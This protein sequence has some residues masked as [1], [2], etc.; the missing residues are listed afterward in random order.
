MVMASRSEK[1]ASCDLV[2]VLIPRP[3]KPPDPTIKV[4]SV[5]VRMEGDAEKEVLRVMTKKE[6]G[7]ERGS[8]SGVRDVDRKGDNPITWAGLF[9]R[10]RQE[11]VWGNSKELQEKISKIQ[12]GAKGKVLIEDEDLE[13]AREECK[14]LLYVGWR[15][16]CLRLKR[17]HLTVVVEKAEDK[18]VSLSNEL[19]GKLFAAFAKILNNEHA[20]EDFLEEGF[21]PENSRGAEKRE[22]NEY[23]WA[24]V[25]IQKVNLIFLFE[26]HLNDAESNSFLGRRRRFWERDFVSSSGRAGGLMMMW[27]KGRMQ[28]NIVYKDEQS[29]NAIVELRKGRFCLVSGIMLVLM[30]RGFKLWLRLRR[31]EEGEINQLV[32]DFWNKNRKNNASLEE[33]LNCL[34]EELKK[35]NKE[36]IGCLESKWKEAMKELEKLETKEAVVGLS[37]AEMQY[38]RMLNRKKDRERLKLQKLEELKWN[39]L[40]DEDKKILSNK[41][42]IEELWNAVFGLGRGKCPRLD[43]YIA[44]FYILNWTSMKDML[45]E[46]VDKVFNINGVCSRRFRSFRGIRQGDP[47]SPYLFIIMEEALS[48][49][50]RSYIEKGKITP[51]QMKDTIISHQ[52][53]ADDILFDIKVRHRRGNDNWVWNESKDGVMT[54]RSAY[55]YLKNKE[56]LEEGPGVV[57]KD[58]WNMKIAQNA[59]VFIWK[60][61]WGRLPV[62]A[63]FSKFNNALTEK[64]WVCKQD[65]D[66]M[67]HIF[68]KCSFANEYWTYAERQLG[69]SFRF[70]NEWGKGEWLKEGE[71]FDRDSATGLKAFLANSFWR[72]WKNRNRMKHDGKSWGV[73]VLFTYVLDET[74]Q[75][76]FENKPLEVGMIK[77]SSNEVEAAVQRFTYQC[78]ASWYQGNRAGFGYLFGSENRWMYASFGTGVADNSLM[79]ETMVM[80]FGLDNVRKKGW[81]GLEACSDCEVLIKMLND[82]LVV[83][84]KLT[85]VIGKLRR[86]K[87]EGVVSCWKYI[88]REINKEAH[89]LAKMGLFCNSNFAWFSYGNQVCLDDE[90]FGLKLESM[91]CILIRIWIGFDAKMIATRMALIVRTGLQFQSRLDWLSGGWLTSSDSPFS[92]YVVTASWFIWHARNT[93]LHEGGLGVVIRDCSGSCLG[94]ASLVYQ[95]DSILVLEA[96]AILEGLKMAIN[97]NLSDFIIESDSATVV[98]SLTNELDPPWVICGINKVRLREMGDMASLRV[99][100][101]VAVLLCFEEAVES[102]FSRDDFPPDFIFG[103]G[104][105]AY[106]VEGAAAEDGRTPSVWDTFTHAGSMPRIELEIRKSRVPRM[107]VQQEPSGTNEAEEKSPS[108]G[109]ECTNSEKMFLGFHMKLIKFA[110]GERGKHMFVIPSLDDTIF[111]LREGN[112]LDDFT[113]FANVCFKEF[114]DR[115]SRW[116]T[117]AQPN[118]I[119]IA[120]YDTGEWPPNRCS[121]PFGLGICASGNS[122]IEPYIAVH[123]I[124][125]AHASVV[126]LYR[127]KYQ[128]VQKGEIG[129]N[130]Y[131]YWCYPFTDSAADIEA[132]QRA[133]DFSIGWIANP[134]VFGDYPEVMKKIVGSRLPSFSK[135]QSKQL[136]GSFDYFG[137]NYYTSAYVM[138]DFN[139]AKTGPH[140]YGADMSVLMK[141]SRNDTPGGQFDPTAPSLIDPRGLQ[142]LL[143]YFRDAY[144]NP[145]IFVEENGYGISRHSDEF[146]DIERVDFLSDHISSTLDA[147]RNGANV[148]GYFVW[149]FM[150]VFEFLAGYQ[151]RCGLYFVN[152]DDERR[153]RRPKLSANWF[154]NFL[155][156]KTKIT[157]NLDDKFHSQV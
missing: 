39:T 20:K 87:N 86:L 45:M 141:S 34:K 97:R 47:L 48:V 93:K 103:A 10:S 155:I 133:L 29:I 70:K 122:T 149:S 83:P 154:T 125:L 46:E 142:H 143:E 26:T 59:K 108:I 57:W 130:L 21:D 31:R 123:N 38:M 5:K 53:F 33:K 64:C 157:M 49:M 129:L 131:T 14:W 19:S 99:I 91:N 156:N 6:E 12:E 18:G 118:V 44:A 43:G 85:N 58:I 55:W 151:S 36:V 40:P 110:D 51:Y 16:W 94:G 147:I 77:D 153:E 35:Y 11:D 17:M 98:K 74:K 9:R 112:T 139:A 120:S 135:D 81:H 138:D 25:N 71:G 145:R 7:K 104:T 146:N 88:S 109:S 67:E 113:A 107:E 89:V 28:V 78:D 115:V 148:K 121:S 144:G 30:L 90:I 140:D 126:K 84:W 15:K 62:A 92:A 80:W 124:L 106:Q 56:V 96:L 117:I 95:G 72:L 105:S 4:D 32:A 132:T 42:S 52:L 3:K 82:E 127:A 63:W 152:F 22:A 116:T 100:L 128:V 101:V 76:C 111:T 137:L 2:P 8:R 102:S 73:K 75:Y 13:V 134:L 68:Y 65:E 27:R 50:T 66:K 37:E 114:G 1:A 79:A 24:M 60:M 69:I 54:V 61:I 41:I 23:L 150:D 136:K 119:G